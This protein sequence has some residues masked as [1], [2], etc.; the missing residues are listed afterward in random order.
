LSLRSS[1][2]I[3]RTARRARADKVDLAIA[4]WKANPLSMIVRAVTAGNTFWPQPRDTK[5][6]LAEDF[7]GNIVRLKCSS[8]Q[9]KVL[10]LLT[11]LA[12]CVSFVILYEAPLIL[13]VV[14]HFPLYCPWPLEGL[15]L[16]LDDLFEGIVQ[17]KNGPSEFRRP[18]LG[19]AKKGA[20][21]TSLKNIFII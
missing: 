11:L 5:V 10:R 2:F 16:C 12:W 4:Y 8:T 20:D 3:S 17:F 7:C 6:S 1:I 13:Y 18:R 21:L 15:P 14:S 9:D 19:Q